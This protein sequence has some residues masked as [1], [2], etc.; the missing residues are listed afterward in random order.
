[1]TVKELKYHIALGT[2][3]VS[4]LRV[5]NIRAIKDY[6]LYCKIYDIF[7]R[8]MPIPYSINKHH[9]N[10]MAFYQHRF[11]KRYT[12]EFILKTTKAILKSSK[13]LI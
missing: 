1:M 10:S 9:N 13:I 12:K 11:Y 5:V 8:S 4:Q 6:E 7:R 2:L 3:D